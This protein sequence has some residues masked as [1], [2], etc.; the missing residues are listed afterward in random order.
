MKNK[1]RF[2]N[3]GKNIVPSPDSDA[4]KTWYAAN[5]CSPLFRRKKCNGETMLEILIQQRNHVFGKWI[6]NV[7]G[8]EQNHNYFFRAEYSCRNIEKET[9]SV[10]AMVSWKS[11]DGR[12]IV[13]EYAKKPSDCNSRW[14]VIESV[15]QAPP[16]AS[17]VLI[18]LQMRWALNGSVVF[19]LPSMMECGIVS[20]R[21]VRIATTL[22]R[23]FHNSMEKNLD[24]VLQLLDRVREHKP[25]IVC[26]T[27]TVLSIGVDLPLN[28]L[29][30]SIPGEFSD[31]IGERCRKYGFYVVLSMM[32][33]EETLIYNTGVLIDR[34]GR[35]AGKYRKTHMPLE[36][37]EQG[38]VPGNTYPV[39]DTDFGRIGIL[40]CWDQNFSEPSRI[41]ALRGAEIVLIPSMATVIRQCAARAADNGLYV[42]VSGNYDENPS[43]VINPVGE[44]IAEVKE[45]ETG[46]CIAEIDLN[47]KL[48]KHWLS[49]GDADGEMRNVFLNERRPDIYR[50]IVR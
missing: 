6:C 38:I 31:I 3:C 41:L 50:D 4:W 18:E 40:I 2:D 26:F 11:S 44:I 12:V 1:N 46:Y 8:I 36:E 23:N 17:Q 32:E 21:K 16:G 9:V 19:R 14:K 42:A 29:A 43:I 39:F 48:R 28:Q 15:F 35:V 22:I 47:R 7:K 27:E 37:A 30:T 45:K 10:S 25:D 20:K 34:K 24:N 33:K 13:R 5:T 49:V